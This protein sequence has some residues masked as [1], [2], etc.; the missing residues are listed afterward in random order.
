VKLLIV[1]D[2]AAARLAMCALLED[3]GHEAREAG[4]LREAR[5]MLDAEPFD[6]VVVDL[7]L[8]DG[9]GSEL[10]PEVRARSPATR[11]AILS[12]DPRAAQ[13]GAADVVLEKGMD[14]GELLARLLGA[15]R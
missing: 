1:D 6:V 13:A 9:H 4:S 11:V 5:A 8:G 10:V 14:P 7:R 15:S 2:H 12:G 3:A